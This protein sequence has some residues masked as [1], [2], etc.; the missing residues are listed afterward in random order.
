MERETRSKQRQPQ[1]MFRTRV[2]DWRRKKEL[3]MDVRRA[4]LSHLFRK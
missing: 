1:S 2:M 4:E 3:V